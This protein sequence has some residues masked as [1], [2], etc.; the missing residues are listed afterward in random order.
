MLSVFT[1]HISWA[2]NG[3]KIKCFLKQQIL[4]TDL[5]GPVFENLELLAEGSACADD[6]LYATA[7]VKGHWDFDMVLYGGNGLNTQQT[8]M[9]LSHG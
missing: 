8:S 6:M 9:A 2:I 1:W 3:Q 7:V 5:L 4:E